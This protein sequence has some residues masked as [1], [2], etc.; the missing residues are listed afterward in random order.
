MPR[1]GVARAAHQQREAVVE[2]CLD[3]A[4]RQRPRPRGGELQRERR[5][6]EARCTSRRSASSSS[7]ANPP[8]APARRTAHAPRPAASGD[9]RHTVSPARPSGS[10]L[11]ASDRH[12]RAAPASARGDLG[13]RVEHVL[14]V[15]EAQQQPPRRELRAQRLRHAPRGIDEHAHRRRHRPPRPAA[16]R[17]RRQLDPPRRRRASGRPARRRAA[18][19][20]PRL[21]APAGP[22]DRQQPRA[23]QPARAARRARPRARRTSSAGSA[24]CSASRRASAAAAAASPSA[25]TRCGSERSRSRCTPRSRNASL[26]A[27]AAATA[28]DTSVCP[29]LA[30]VAQPPRAGGVGPAWTASRAVGSAARAAPPPPPAPRPPTGRRSTSSPV[31]RNVANLTRLILTATSATSRPIVAS[32]PMF[33]AARRGIVI[34]EP[35]TPDPE[36]APP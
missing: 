34:G 36:G 28:A 33:F 22:G 21:A 12:L 14:A 11:V 5:A 3:L 16:G 10:R 25:N 32:W 18:P 17:R 26:G 7:S 15:V 1:H 27:A 23:G 2:P 13:D 35:R 29:G 8:C 9:S 19:H 24:G 20:Q 4:R 30:I 6:V 31:A